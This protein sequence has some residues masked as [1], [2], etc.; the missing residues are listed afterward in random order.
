MRGLCALLACGALAFASSAPGAVTKKVVIRLKSITV[1]SSYSDR[2]PK[3]PSK[4]DVFRGRFR[5]LNV[6]PQFGRK[7]GAA[8][9]TEHSTLTFASSTSASISGAVAL[10]GG[11]LSYRGA[12]RIGSS[13]P[14]P[15]VGGH[16]T[17]RAEPAARS[18][19]ATAR[20]RSTHTG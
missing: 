15:V 6:V 2:G 8:V 4:G 11:T 12:G 5:L 19:S 20:R 1:A 9:G 17:L 7:A 18:S 3:G 16:R 14:I 10:P 13:T